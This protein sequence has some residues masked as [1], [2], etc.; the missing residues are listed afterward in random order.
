MKEDN[1]DTML[2]ALLLWESADLLDSPAMYRMARIMRDKALKN[3]NQSLITPR[4]NKAARGAI[5]QT[6]G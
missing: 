2:A 6:E 5:V 4:V 1:H 3:A